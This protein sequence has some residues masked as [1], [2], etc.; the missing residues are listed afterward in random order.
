MPQS[1][2]KNYIHIIFSTKNRE[3]VLLLP[4][5]K[6]LFAYIGGICKKMGCLPINVG[7]YT[8]HIHVLCLLSKNVALVKLVEVIKSYSSKWI[9]E[10]GEELQSF[11]WQEGYGAFSVSPSQLDL[12]KAYI[13]KQ[14]E[15]HQQKG[16]QEEYRT[17]LDKYEMDYNE[18]YVWD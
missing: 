14:E 2:A 1:L 17:I 13:D 11:Y 3:P 9:K 10:N 7:G 8:D 16:F 15:H 12:L 5:R 18:K 6:N 4:F